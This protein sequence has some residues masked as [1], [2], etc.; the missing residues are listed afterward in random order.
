MYRYHTD[1]L[2]HLFLRVI[3]RCGV[4]RENDY[5]TWLNHYLRTE[6]QRDRWAKC[7]FKDAKYYSSRYKTA[8][9]ETCRLEFC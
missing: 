1:S 4:K 5:S 6:I 7:S 2:T 9:T 8:E 3:K